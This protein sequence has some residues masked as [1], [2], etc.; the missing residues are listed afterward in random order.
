MSSPLHL[1]FF[2]CRLP[3][4]SSPR[5]SSM[6]L[7]VYFSRCR[8]LTSFLDVALFAL[9]LLSTSTDFLRTIL[10]IGVLSSLREIPA[11]PPLLPAGGY[12]HDLKPKT[13]FRRHFLLGR[14][15]A[16]QNNYHQISKEISFYRKHYSYASV[17]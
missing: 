2:R 4:T 7:N 15:L 8:F 10:A 9:Y 3:S 17:Y 5:L 13:S 11:K 1:F 12:R 6:L 16:A 14:S